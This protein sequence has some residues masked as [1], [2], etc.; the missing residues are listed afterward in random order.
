LR[1]SRRH[2]YR[3]VFCHLPTPRILTRV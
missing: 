3:L 1:I 2:V